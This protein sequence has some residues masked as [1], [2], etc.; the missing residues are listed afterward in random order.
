MNKENLEYKKLFEQ[1]KYSELIFLIQASKKEGEL[2]AGELNLLGVTRLLVEK[3]EKTI[4][5]SLK[6]FE[7]AYLK[8][9]NSKIGLDALKNFINLTVDL[10]K[11]PETEIDTNK[12]LNYFKE[13]RNFWGYDKNLMLAIKRLY[14]RL[15]EVSKVQSILFEMIKNQEHDST[16]LC[17]Y[18]YSKG[19]DN[20][21]KQKDFFEFAEFLQKQTIDIEKNNLVKLKT[22]KSKKLK[23]GFLSGDIRSNH[24]V[25][26]FLK[27]V[28]LNYDR[29]NFQ[30]YL[31]FNHETDD[32]T[33]E[34]FKK[35]VY[36][37]ENINDLND[38]EAINLVRNDEIDIAFDLMGA[39]SSHRETLFKN[40]I[41]PTQINWIGYCNTMG[42]K[43]NNYIIADPHLINKNEEHLYSEKIIYMPQIWNCHS[44]SKSER[45]FID[46][47][48]RKNNF[49][50][51]C[52]FNNFCKINENVIYTWSQIL[53]AIKNSKLIL[54]PSGRLD[55][56]RLKAEFKNCGVENSLIFKKNLKSVKD[57]LKSYNDIDLALDTFPYNGVTTS[58][59]AIWMGVPVL[60]MKGYNFN[61]RCGESINK[62]IGMESMIAKDEND[63]INKAI[64]LSKNPEKLISIRKKIFEDAISSPLFNTKNYTN[65][66]FNLI[67][68]L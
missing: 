14:W 45:E 10:Y 28:L 52:S 27:T 49:I 38:T 35:L 63:Y 3:N 7:E 15:N 43:E 64:E 17:S 40:K 68:N 51:F 39:T 54:K 2:S 19:F 16:T 24:S 66:F 42:L 46:A 13:A 5:M 48:Y 61:S 41:A 1:K 12:T 34:D 4:T 50:T 47:P 21:W 8:D 55:A 60:T 58:F 9:K 59:E 33:T 32:E 67:K 37:S 53:K 30:I 20:N 26:Y 6:N 22:T 57:H 65:N 44:G 36:K 11:F 31:Y 23:L 62:N 56:R 25:T 29:E 18:I